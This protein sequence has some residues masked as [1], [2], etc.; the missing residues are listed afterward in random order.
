M[1]KLKMQTP[2][3]VD[4]NVEQI[5][6]IF[7]EVIT[8]IKDTEGNTKKGIDFDLLKQKLSNVLVE[9]E[10]ERYRLD[11]PGKK[12][13]LLKANTPINKTLRPAVEES[14]NFETTENLYIEGDNFEVLKILQESYLGK[15]KMIYIDPPYNTGTSL[16]YNNDFRVEEKIYAEELGA[17]T[18][19]GFKMFRN[20]DADGRIHSN[21]LSLMYERII[22][23]RDILDEDGIICITID[24][25]ELGR[26]LVLMDEIFGEDNHLG[27]VAIRI[28]PKGRMTNREI[29]AVHEYALF[30]AKS[31]SGRIN[32][33]PI[34]PTEKSHNY[35]ED[36]DGS[37]YLP[38]NLRKQGVDSA[39]INSKGKL[40]DRYY[41]IYF[42]QKTGKVSTI[43]KYEIEILP[44]DP[45]NEKRIWRRAKTEIEKMYAQGDII[46]KETTNGLQ[47]Y[48]K[49]RGG[50]E[51]QQPKSMWYEPKFS[52]SEY[53]TKEVD[54]LFGMRE[55]FSYPKAPKAVE[56]AIKIST[57]NKNA[58]ILDFFS[59][60]ATT[61][62][63][64]MQL[65]AED[66]GNRKFIMVQLPEKTDETSETYKAGYKTIAEIGK[67]RIRRAGK[68]IMN[69]K[70]LIMNEKK[71]EL[72]KLKTKLIKTEEENEKIAEL[73]EI[74]H[75]SQFIINNLDIGFRVYKVDSSNMKDVYYHPAELKQDDLGLLESNIKEDRTPED[76]LTQVILD[77]GLELSL[78]IEKKVIV[79]G[80]STPLSARTPLSAQA[81]YNA[82]TSESRE[83]DAGNTVFIVQENALVACFDDNIDFETGAEQSRSIV[84]KIAELKPFKVVF[85]DAS[86]KDDKDRINVEERFKRLSPE[87]IV[88]VI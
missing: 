74:I 44:I 4:K 85:K 47:V 59:G 37:W 56:E 87:T 55:L 71:E 36:K 53:G 34:D 66:G 38:I 57:T 1:N 41:P 39:A 64:V 27:T 79:P 81:P 73:E 7:P 5:G 61:A 30:Y 24:D 3:L 49:F 43:E 40:S 31:E 80:A 45:N 19:E 42:D 25:Y 58:I 23:S 18:E 14:L 62:H 2:N 76:L 11:W 9:D 20:T 17:V 60:S 35:I 52:A 72:E 54:R 82:Q 28:N 21:W 10:N 86:F 75:N 50:L 33:L 26:L 84:D 78:K 13:S 48:F 16:I 15:V 8:E 77:L 29:S 68:K 63:A 46:I 22:V 83:T 67:E 12:A 70:L 32:K 69:D 6:K 51:G 65:N 88:S